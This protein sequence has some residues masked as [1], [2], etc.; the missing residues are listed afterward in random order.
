[1]KLDKSY[2][3]FLV[4]LKAKISE[5]RYVAARSVNTGLIKPYWSI[6][7]LSKDLK[8]SFPEMKGFSPRNLGYMKDFALIWNDELILQQVVAKLPWAHNI[9]LLEKISNNSKQLWYAKKSIENGW[10]RSTLVM[11]IESKLKNRIESDQKTHNFDVALP[12]AQ[13]D[14]ANNTL[15]DPYIF[16]FLSIGQEAQEREIENKKELADLFKIVRWPD[17]RLLINQLN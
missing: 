8:E 3:E 1:M 4:D 17:M 14:L 2:S 13:S 7:R 6:G 16:D 11:Q 12:K 10:S 5:S 9:T 15:K